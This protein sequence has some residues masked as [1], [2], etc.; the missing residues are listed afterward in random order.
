MPDDRPV[1]PTLPPNDLDALSAY[2]DNQLSSAE[3]AALEAR[4]AAEPILREQLD[5][6]QAVQQALRGLPELRSPRNLTLTAA[7]ARPVRHIA[8]FPAFVSGLS[9]VAAILLI[10]AGLGVLRPAGHALNDEAQLAV[11]AAP[12][13]TATPAAPSLPAAR[14]AETTLTFVPVPGM[15]TDGLFESAPAAVEAFSPAGTIEPGAAGAAF[16]AQQPAPQD[17]QEAGAN[18]AALGGAAAATGNSS[19][20][21]AGV[22][23]GN[24]LPAALPTSGAELAMQAQTTATGDAGTTRTKEASATPAPSETVAPASTATPSAT[25]AATASPAPTGTTAPTPAPIAAPASAPPDSISLGIVLIG[26]GGLL[27]AV[28]VW[29]WRRARQAH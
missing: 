13:A 23:A 20:A 9:A 28:A 8:V 18:D 16:A 17:A 4:L 14:G 12:T 19:E 2:L 27:A 10:A 7:Q 22:V 11:A 6:L 24:A 1:N 29:A 3:R 15:S 25:P 26:L 21:T 5:G